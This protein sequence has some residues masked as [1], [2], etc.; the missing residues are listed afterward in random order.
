[1]FRLLILFLFLFVCG[2]CFLTCLHFNSQ[3]KLLAAKK[4]HDAVLSATKVRQHMFNPKPFQ[5]SLT[6]QSA[7]VERNLFLQLWF[8][9]F[10]DCL[11]EELRVEREQRWQLQQRVAQLEDETAELKWCVEW[12]CSCHHEWWW[13]LFVL[14]SLRVSLSK[15]IS[16]P[17]ARKWPNQRKR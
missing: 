6:N 9:V 14:F 17:K 5:P 4:K 3:E 1:M 2:F 7:R 10:V 13:W 8:S 11:Q 16:C 15:G 12:L